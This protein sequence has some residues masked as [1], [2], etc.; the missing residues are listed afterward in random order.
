[1]IAPKLADG[2]LKRRKGYPPAQ[3]FFSPTI[4][5]TTFLAGE[6][7][8]TF[9]LPPVRGKMTIGP[10]KLPVK[11]TLLLILLPMLATFAIQRLYLHLVGVQHVRA[12][13]LIIHHLFFGVMIV[14]PAA[15]V[16]AFGP[17]NHTSAVLS[18]LALG[19]GSAMILD[20]MV[21]LTA[22]QASDSDYVSAL[23]LKGAVI[24]ISLGTALLLGLYQWCKRSEV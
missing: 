1:M 12:S 20:E 11:Q 18:R 23:S 15:F 22:T 21:Y 6:R 24:F 14:L 19:I 9:G 4:G 5:A 17:R 16:L 2:C 8:G 7:L 3:H 13:G 10:M